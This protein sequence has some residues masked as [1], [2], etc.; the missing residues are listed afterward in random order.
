MIKFEM[1]YDGNWRRRSADFP[2]DKTLHSNSTRSDADRV[3][4]LM[5]TKNQPCLTE[6]HPLLPRRR[7][8]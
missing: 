8:R 7:D 2:V 4:E 5:K 6:P 1:I 3:D